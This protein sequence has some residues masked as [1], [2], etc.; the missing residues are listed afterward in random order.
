MQQEDAKT[1]RFG[2]C[3]SLIIGA[4]IEVH[5]ALGPGLLE[6]AYER[7]LCR[8]LELR[9]V[10]YER[11]RAL[12]VRYKGL[13][14][15]CSYR[16]DVVVEDSIIVEIKAVEQLTRVHQAQMLTYLRLSGLPTGLIINFHVAVIRDGIRRLTVPS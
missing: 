4:C 14:I 13:D 2:D 8:E 5:K 15:D 12:P 7:C 6:S 16:L 11:Q 10:S 9:G 3:S 1:G